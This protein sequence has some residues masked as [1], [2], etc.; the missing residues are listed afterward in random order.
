M[1][2]ALHPE[3]EQFVRQCVR[4][5]MQQINRLEVSQ[6]GI[7]AQPGGVEPDPQTTLMMGQPV[8]GIL[9]LL[10][11]LCNRADPGADRAPVPGFAAGLPARPRAV[12]DHHLAQPG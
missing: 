3:V 2:V 11:M 1:V 12:P 5:A 9:F 4:L 10:Q 7:L 8:G 6:A